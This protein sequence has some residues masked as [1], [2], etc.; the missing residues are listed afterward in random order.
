MGEVF[1]LEEEGNIL[2]RPIPRRNFIL[3][4]LAAAA[5][6]VLGKELTK[7]NIFQEKATKLWEEFEK[8]PQEFLKNHPSGVIE[9]LVVGPNGVNLRNI[10]STQGGREGI[11]G[12][13]KPNESTGTALVFPNQRADPDGPF[14]VIKK[15]GNIVFVAE[16][17]LTKANPKLSNP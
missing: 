16:N 2:S 9:E 1:N 11:V 5:A 8:N 4:G 13:L 3:G 15:N 7:Q 12:Y 14:L 6:F 10:P 17:Q